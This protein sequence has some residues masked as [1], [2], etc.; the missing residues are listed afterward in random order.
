[1]K[2]L[3][4]GIVTVL[5]TGLLFTGFAGGCAEEEP[6]PANPAAIESTATDAAQHGTFPEIPPGAEICQE[7]RVPEIVCPFCNQEFVDN[8]GQCGG[9]G[10]PEALCTRCHPI[11]IAAFKAEGDW[12]E[13]HGLPESQCTICGG[14]DAGEGAGAEAG[15]MCAQHNVPES[16]CPFCDPSLIEKL[17]HCNGHDVPEALC[18]RCN[19]QLVAAFKA[20]GD[21]CHEHGLP[22]SQCLICKGESDG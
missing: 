7:H 17:G 19:S 11:L 16:M 20:E 18:T 10:V 21:W 1:M 3:T 5:V 12:C 22:E 8:A 15:A 2:A 13:E 4:I 14:G 6:A 9:H